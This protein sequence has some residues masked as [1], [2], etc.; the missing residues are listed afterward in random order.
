[1]LN[2][3]FKFTLCCCVLIFFSGCNNDSGNFDADRIKS[4][5]DIPGI[6]DEEIAAIKAL[7]SSKRNF[8]LGATLSAE[9]FMYSDGT[10]SGFSDLLADFFSGMFDMPFK[11]KIVNWDDALR[12]F[13]NYEIDFM[14]ELTPTA[15]RR[16]KYFM[17]APIAER[18]LLVFVNDST[19]D[20]RIVNDLNGLRVGF[21]EG[22]ITGQS[23]KQTYPE[24]VFETVMID[25][26]PHAARM[27]LDSEVDVVI[28]D[29]PIDYEFSIQGNITGLNLLPLVY[30]PV[31]FSTANPELDIIIK[32]LDKYIISGGLEKI[33]SLYIQGEKDYAQF[34]FEWSLTDKE[35]K[36]IADLKESG[37]KVPVTKEPDN[38]PLCFYDKKIK[39]F[40]GIAVDIIN[41]VSVLTG[42]EFETVTNKNTTIAEILEIIKSGG[43]AFDAELI[44][45]ELR[46]NNFLFP[47]TPYFISN[48]ALLSKMDYPD[49]KIY[50]VAGARV[51][52]VKGTAP[53]EL[54]DML[55]PGCSSYMEYNT[56]DEALDALEKNKIDLFLTTDYMLLYQT[57]FREKTGYKIN[58]TINS[59]IQR[60]FFGFNKNEEILC[61]IIE[62]AVNRIN[63]DKIVS[64]WTN[65]VYDYSKKI[66]TNS[67]L[68][69]SIFTAILAL[70][71]IIMIRLLLKNRKMIARI[72]RQNILLNS[73]NQFSSILL[74]PEL[75]QDSHL[76]IFYHFEETI[77]DAMGV[78]VEAV[79]VDRICI[80]INTHDKDRLR[81]TLAYE[82]ESGIFRTRSRN[83]SLTPDIYFDEHHPWNDVLSKGNCLNS[84]V[85]DMAPAEQAEL[86]PRN[87]KSLLVV[88]IF[89]QND[90]WGFVSFDH[91]KKECLFTDSEI[92]IMRS[93]S[94]MI[95]NAI[96][97]NEMTSQLKIAKEQA[98]QSNR[99]KSIF[100]SHMSHEI[101][102]PMN[103]ILGIAEIQLQREIF[104]P[105]TTECFEK[106]YESGDLLL[107][108]INDILDLSKIESGK[109]ELNPIIYDIP[110]L[111]N[112]TVQLNHLRYESKPIQ[113]ILQIEK[114][115]P[116]KLIGD[117][118]R[119]KQVLNNILSNAFKYTEKGSIEFNVSTE[120]FGAQENGDSEKIILVFSVKDTGQGMTEEQL[121]R[122]FDEYTRFNLDTNRTTVG[123]GLG[124]T[125][126]K[127]LVDFM[128]GVINVESVPGVGS[129][130]TVKIPQKRCGAEV[131][132]QDVIKRLENFNFH[133]TTIL[134]KVQFIRE[135]MPY[136][137]VLVVDDVE[138]NIYVARG[139]MLPY[140]LKVDTATSGFIALDK[141]SKGGVYDIIF[142]DHMMPKMDGIETVRQIRDMGYSMPIVALT[143]NALIGRSKMFLQNGFDAFLSKPI[144]SRELNFVLLE[145]IRNR[146]PPEVVDAARN[147]PVSE[148]A[149]LQ[150][151]SWDTEETRA[152]KIMD[153]FVRDAENAIR[154]MEKVSIDDDGIEQY[155]TAVHGIK[156]ALANIGEKE[157]SE[158]ALK[159]ENNARKRN[160]ELLKNATPTFINALKTLIQ[161]FKY[162]DHSEDFA[163]SETLTE[164]NKT[165]LHQKLI[166]LKTACAEYDKKTAKAALEALDAK[167][168][169]EHI[170]HS[171]NDISVSLLHS[172]F[173]EIG[174]QVDRIIK[175]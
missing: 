95:S 111:I 25:D 17:T 166:E 54:F 66:A 47:K 104:S 141:V 112:D 28:V 53:A 23:V 140:G 6:T 127:R 90:F 123:A 174:E 80:W 165:F 109:L 18:A 162:I 126:T 116:F 68:Y 39:D 114:N 43:A 14:I 102:T 51:G 152:F 122:I 148:R 26:V 156:S 61:S 67:L 70:L 128:S 76:G 143:A 160:Y 42:I 150:R 22:T 1:M 91:C 147:V 2:R 164:E 19:K 36:Y 34:M 106:I 79:G 158:I 138:S 124:M 20:I 84:F 85:R 30:T 50:Q 129:V 121:G 40:H 134:K 63:V 163:D 144:D 49:L 175:Q 173:T 119:I 92:L 88:P 21:F 146:K 81:F 98:E 10:N 74:E 4:Y 118:L 75:S 113:F 57:H 44:Y 59:I 73:N 83:G 155:I 151:Q 99:S 62:K 100:L 139:M 55:I 46:E 77:R 157:L 12:G 9:T 33:H 69:M 171:L 45:T 8:I 93:G 89:I 86:T 108:I 120:A 159:M 13:E 117:V 48:F 168:W 32:V 3:I 11:L 125:I 101:R 131:C 161:N 65:R 78:M 56:R 64:Q 103:A 37:K 137:S 107:N 60:S 105:E 135:Y 29:E 71:L 169:P 16:Q 170:V 5:I 82:W 94:R 97:R 52:T 154:V 132:S 153:F 7:K 35:K 172:E 72:N 31:S 115:M 58:I 38:Y 41:E 149:A 87:I 133:N 145:Y 130:F 15:D 142:M 167:I 27:L 96:I 136:G 24:L 110:S